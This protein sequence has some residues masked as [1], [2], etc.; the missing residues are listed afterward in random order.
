MVFLWDVK[1]RLNG[2]DVKV[3]RSYNFIILRIV[4]KTRAAPRP[5]FTCLV[6]PEQGETEN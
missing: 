2:T 4:N 1:S 6:I 5:R 3:I